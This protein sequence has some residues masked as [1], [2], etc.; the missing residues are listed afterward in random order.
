MRIIE[1]RPLASYAILSLLGMGLAL[2]L[3]GCNYNIDK[4]AGRGG[5]GSLNIQPGDVPSF[6]AVFQAVLKPKCATCHGNAVGNRGGINLETFENVSRLQVAIRGTVVDGDP[7]PMPPSR[8]PQLTASEKQFLVAWLDAG[9]PREGTAA[10]PNE[11][12]P[13]EP[14]PTPVQPPVANEPPP[15]AAEPPVTP[16]VAAPPAP[17]G[18]VFAEVFTQVIGPRCA[19]CHSEAGGNRGGVNLETFANV[20]SELAAID[21]AVATGFMP[22]RR[23]GPLTPEQK[24][25]L[26]RWIAAGAPQ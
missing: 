17:A 10:A 8:A 6:D 21:E 1:R 13:A 11:P 2:S 22:P 19:G 3:G 24:D 18:P 16:P 20:K 7:L 9:A 14:E 23:S 15:V 26:A 25:L 12:V 5:E 4:T